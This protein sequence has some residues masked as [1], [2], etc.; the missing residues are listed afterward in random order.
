M[1]LTTI[2]LSVLPFTILAAPSLLP[3][4]ITALSTF[5]PSG[6]SGN[7]PYSSLTVTITDPNTIP[8][9]KTHYSSETSFPPSNATCTTKWNSYISES[10]FD[11]NIPCQSDNFNAGRWSV[12]M[13]KGNGTGDG[14][15]ATRDFRLRFE[16]EESM[17]LNEGIVRKTFVG[18]AGFVLVTPPQIT[19]EYNPDLLALFY[20]NP[21]PPLP[22]SPLHTA[23]PPY[24]PPA[25]Y[26]PQLHP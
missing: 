4:K 10:P 11:K 8:L 14:P 12:V 3:W 6:R 21:P 5:T 15:S 13:Q 2:L 22:T 17:M 24:S 1:H 25:S 26:T 7:P 23:P 16:L 19:P 18:T 9:G 20:L